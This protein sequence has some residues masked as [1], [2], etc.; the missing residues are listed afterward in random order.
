MC[1]SVYGLQRHHLVARGL[2]GSRDPYINSEENEVTLCVECHAKA[3]A[4]A[5]GY[6]REELILA[7]EK[8]K[9]RQKRMGALLGG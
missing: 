4:H 3:E 8:D 7:K 9:E 2:G 5:E 6:S 1:G